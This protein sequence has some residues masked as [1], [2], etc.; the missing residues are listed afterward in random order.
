MTMQ[1]SISAGRKSGPVSQ[2][3]GA[4]LF[5]FQF[6]AGDPTFNGHFPGRPILPG[7]F[8][9]EMA[10]VSAEAILNV[11]LAIVE[12]RK[13]KFQRPILPDEAV[14]VELK[15]SEKN[16]TIETRANFSIGGEAAGETI[17]FLCRKK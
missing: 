8:Q 11:P 16:G 9:L 1:H 12:V 15:L 2:P 13:A 3:D 5:E 6:S 10:R 7:I 14:R 4:H 17:L